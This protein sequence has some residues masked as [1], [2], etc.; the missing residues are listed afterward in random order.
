MKTIALIPAYEP[1]RDFITLLKELVYTKYSIVVVDDGSGE[2]YSEIFKEA[3]KYAYI[4]SYKQ[5]H[6]KGYALKTGLAYIAHNF[7]S[8]FIV[9]TLDSDGQHTVPDVLNVVEEAAHHPYSLTLGVR[10]FDDSTPARSRFGNTVTRFVYHLSTGTRVSDTQTGLRAFGS[11]LLQFMLE[12]KGDRYEY[13]M[14]VLLDCPEKNIGIYEVPIET[15]Y[16]DKNS[17]SHFHTFRDSFLVYGR[18]LKFAA[19]S[20]ASFVIDYSLYSL[21]VW[22]LGGL[23]AAVAV[24]ISNISARI[25]SAGA[26]FSINKRYIFHNKDSVM[27]TGTQYFLLAACI[28]AGNTLLLSFL[29]TGIGMNKFVAKIITE[30]TFFT[31]SFVVQRFWIFRK[32]SSQEQSP[33]LLRTEFPPHIERSESFAKSKKA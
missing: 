7:D 33:K 20:M 15:V 25:V 8:P 30:L 3:E 4:I 12:S 1:T 22:L 32:K 9:V 24:P 6:G 26:N 29:V 5:N 11:E 10:A 21:L 2:N 18:F 13:E 27:K 16:M 17:G 19:S 14:N 28:L 31:I 23:G